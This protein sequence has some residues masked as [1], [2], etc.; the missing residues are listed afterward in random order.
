MNFVEFHNVLDSAYGA[1]VVRGITSRLG[2][3]AAPERGV[4]VAK[5]RE[6]LRGNTADAYR[7]A[8]EA[9]TAVCMVQ[10]LA[11]AVNTIG[12]K[13][14][15]MKELAK[16]ASGADYSKLQVEQMQKEFVG[17]AKG[18]NEIVKDT[19]FDFNKL[20]TAE[21]ETIS[22]RVT[23]DT[24]IDIFAKDLSFNSE[25]LDLTKDPAGALGEITKATAT[26]N[27]YS[28]FLDRQ[29]ERLADIM[30][31]VDAELVAAVN[32]D[33]NDF[34]IELTWQLVSYAK[35]KFLEEPVALLDTQAN[36]DPDRALRLLADEV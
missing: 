11:S 22:I 31:I 9:S 27:E 8:H 12:N 35:H 23:Q 32:E 21:G 3:S 29:G 34:S 15:A 24:K 10:T 18:I 2:G 5:L 6:M 13:L 26:L 36:A 25:G 4:A 14:G 33:L 16:N 20:L 7:S 28:T 19:E 30:A 17:L 1:Y